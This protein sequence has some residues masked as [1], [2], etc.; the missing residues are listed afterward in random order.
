MMSFVHITAAE[1]SP[2]RARRDCYIPDRTGI[3]RRFVWRRQNLSRRRRFG[4]STALRRQNILKIIL[5]HFQ[6]YIILSGHYCVRC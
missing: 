4:S 5:F 1:H 3:L 6:K 2:R